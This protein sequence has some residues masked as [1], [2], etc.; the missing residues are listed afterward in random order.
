MLTRGSVTHQYGEHHA[1]Y[2]PPPFHYYGHPHQYPPA[3][4]RPQLYGAGG[5]LGGAVTLTA[6]GY[7]GSRMGDTGYGYLGMDPSAPETWPRPFNPSWG[8]M[9]RFDWQ[10]RG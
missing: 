3:M 8:M 5:L 7:V 6:R 9:A 2:S 1:D 10:A 4:D